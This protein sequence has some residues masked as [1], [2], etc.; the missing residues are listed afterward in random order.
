M[1]HF[2]RTAIATC[3]LAMLSASCVRATPAEPEERPATADDDRP[4]QPRKEGE[5]EREAQKTLTVTGVV[6]SFH[7]GRDGTIDGLQ[8]DDGT[9]VRFPPN[10]S[11]KLTAVVSLKDR[12]TVEGWSHAGEAEIHAARV[13]NDASGRAV[14]VDR[15]PPTVRQGDQAPRRPRDEEDQAG[16]APPRRPYDGGPRDKREP[17]EQGPPKRD[18]E[19]RYS[20]E[21][22]VSDEA[23][24]HTIAFDGLAFLT[25]DFGS[26]TFLPPGKVCDYFGFQYMRDFDRAEGGHNTSFLTR[27]ANNMLAILNDGQKSQLVALGKEQEDDIRRFA[28]LRLPLIRAFRRNLE[29]ALPA[30]SKG[31]DKKAVVAYSAD[32]YE[33]DGRLALQR[34]KV[35]GGILY[36]LD[37]PQK[38][39]LAK[40]KFDD[41][42]TWPNLPET[43]DRKSLSHTVHVAVM[44]YA[45]EMFAWYAGSLEADTYFCPERHGMYFGGF[46]MKTAPAMGKKDYSISTTLTGDSGDAFLRTLN[47]GQRKRVTDLVELQRQDLAEIVKTRRAIASELRRFLKGESA[48]EKKV[49]FLSRR[50]GELDGEM[51]YLYATAFAE[52]G[53]TLTTGQRD[54]LARMRTSNSSD[55]R[56]PFLYSSP[57]AMP[58]IE[59]TDSFFGARGTGPDAPSAKPR[60]QG[61]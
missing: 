59:N 32:L 3:G 10:A 49:L 23:Q 36:S 25:G 46:G 4:P 14:D 18:G 37:A 29:G 27:I 31:L 6:T 2:F 39:A 19:K 54:K 33:L 20:L 7:K 11:A 22:A 45:S 15:V 56:G 28:E 21:Q 58:K 17:R 57:I 16:K 13:K 38:A 50:Y 26:D 48:D 42:R 43:L 51:S 55:P 35:M 53:K 12:V 5:P 40:L 47:D 41:S 60:A 30:G 9:E 61:K 24:L 52:I 34:A 44:T 1:R 8:L